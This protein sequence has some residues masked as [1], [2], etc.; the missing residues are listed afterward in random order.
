MLVNLTMPGSGHLDRRSTVKI[1]EI[2]AN[3]KPDSKGQTGKAFILRN[4]NQRRHLAAW[5]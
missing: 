4:D 2:G 1:D 3:E 5:G